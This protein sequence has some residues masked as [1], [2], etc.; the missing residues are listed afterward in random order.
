MAMERIHYQG[1]CVDPNNEVSCLQVESN[2]VKTNASIVF[3]GNYC[4]HE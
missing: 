2:T 3:K 1:N 4:K